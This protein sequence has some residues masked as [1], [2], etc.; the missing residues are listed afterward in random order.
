[1]KFTLNQIFL[2]EVLAFVSAATLTM[3]CKSMGPSKSLVNNADG[4][5]TAES[6]KSSEVPSTIVHILAGIQTRN[7]DDKYLPTY[8]KVYNDTLWSGIWDS[9]GSFTIKE[10]KDGKKFISILADPF[11]TPGPSSRPHLWYLCLTN[12]GYKNPVSFEPCNE[13]N[14][15]QKMDW[16]PDAHIEDPTGAFIKSGNLCL[17]IGTSQKQDKHSP[18]IKNTD[19]ALMDEGGVV[20]FWNCKDHPGE[21]GIN[22]NQR[23]YRRDYQQR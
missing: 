14:E 17:D 19:L 18:P 3:S 7:L 15:N 20:R 12:R 10:L 6:A 22:Y 4:V 1:M 9:R 5:S 23:F 2:K 8:L 11:Y 21:A 13:N 16:N